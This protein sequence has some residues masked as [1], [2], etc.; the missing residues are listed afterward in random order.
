MM[1][2]HFFEKTSV[3]NRGF[4]LIEFA[5][6]NGEECSIQ[7][8]SAI[9]DSDRGYEK[10]GTS[11]LWIGCDKNSVHPRTGEALSPRMHL[12]R[13]HVQELVAVLNRW[14][15]TGSLAGNE[16]SDAESST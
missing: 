2:R 9:D 4:E 3:T 11:Y 16:D 5:D 10:P 15:D 6:G 13:E 12:H 1:T 14:L 7:Q 8:S